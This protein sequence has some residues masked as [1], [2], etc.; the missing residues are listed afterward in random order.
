MDIE[1]MARYWSQD[2]EKN[3]LRIPIRCLIWAVEL[4][5]N[6]GFGDVHTEFDVTDKLWDDKEQLLYG[7]TPMFGVFSIFF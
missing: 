1:S 5:R 2:A 7:E 4:L 6:M 3:C